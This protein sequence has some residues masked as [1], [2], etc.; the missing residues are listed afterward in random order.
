MAEKRARRSRKARQ[1]FFFPH[2]HYDIVWKFSREDY[3]YVNLRLLRQA[4]TL[5]SL[6]PEFRFGVED[7]QQ[8]EEAE[9]MDPGLFEKIK[10]MAAQGRIEVIDGQY[11]MA[12]S[13][14]PGGEALVS[15]ILRGKRYVRE[16]LGQDIPVGW[17]TD[18]F[19]L[20]AQ[21]PQLY[22][23]AGYRWVA[24]GRGFDR[25]KGKSEFW[26]EGLDGT[27]ILAHYFASSHSYHVGLFG[28]YLRENI[29]ELA[30]YAATESVLLPCGI[31]S[32][33]FPE[34]LLKELDNFNAR[35]SD[36]QIKIASPEEFFR[37]VE[38]MGDKLEVQKGEMYQGDRV[39]D[40][41]WSTR[42]WVKLK[43]FEMEN[44]LLNAEKF[45]TLAW[46]FGKAY[47]GR[48]LG[49]A[50]DRILFLAFHDVL[51]GTSID[52]VYE[53]VR[54]DFRNLEA[55]LKPI[56][57]SSLSHLLS[58]VAPEERVLVV[59]NPNSFEVYDYVEAEIRFPEEERMTN[60]ELEETE[61]ELIDEDRG[62]RGWLRWAKVGLMAQV[63]PL[64]YRTYR[65][66]PS[67]APMARRRVEPGT[68]FIENEGLRVE[69]NH[70]D[71]L[72]RILNAD[73]GEEVRQ[74][75]LEIENEVGSVY[76]H[77]DI[78]RELVGL[79][80]AE[81]DTSPN[82]PVFKITGFRVEKN[83]ICQRIILTEELYG[84][85]WPYRLREH[86]GMEFYRQKL[87]E[88]E[89]EISLYSGIPWVEFKLRLR[90]NF[91]HVRLRAVVDTGL[92][93]G[94]CTSGTIFGAVRR[95]EDER[96]YPMNGWV[97]YSLGGRGVAVLTQGIP[98]YQASEGKIRLTLLRSVDLLSHGDKGPIVPVMGALEL[99][100]D[101]EFNFAIYPHRGDWKE[102]KVWV[103]ALGF[104]NRPICRY[105]EARGPEG[106]G[107][108]QRLPAD[109][110]SFL[111]LPENVVLSRLK[112]SEDGDGAI[113]RFYEASGETTK[114]RLKFWKAPREILKSNV[115]EDKKERGTEKLELRPFQIVTLK[116]GF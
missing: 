61:W 113:L 34:W 56:L 14:L 52:E 100:Q 20:N 36:Y 31:G 45:A 109:K 30:S 111:S 90:S 64:G 99:G 84:C 89:K 76:S 8:L 116:L 74:V 103:R 55:T 12:D 104:A 21:T 88:L 25:Q 59:F 68:D 78:S 54:S 85:F 92:R 81:G 91:P 17:I 2:F 57:H 46:L 18:S 101:Y 107:S 10:E 38:E 75:R 23:D 108:G 44:L 86:Y 50:W 47:P 1:V 35:N 70:L 27:R 80:G 9:H 6:F 96:D 28:E 26:W 83:K 3:S 11:L 33:P 49:R 82:K 72:C 15:E 110:F 79:I 32:C 112:R 93:A 62:R 66:V 4:I 67:E 65:I 13:F 115:L 7:V 63:P 98:G 58:L 95:R 42:M 43:Y 105:V 114:L 5:C 106:P 16:K 39:F 40:G 53:E 97:D 71:G 60:F 29:Q 41:V 73:G 37:A 19:G 87:M 48:E 24:F 102:S 51:P 77:R 94:E 69:V 22:R